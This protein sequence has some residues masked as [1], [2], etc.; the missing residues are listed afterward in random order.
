MVGMPNFV[1]VGQ[2]QMTHV[3]T[4]NI[5]H[6]PRLC[7]VFSSTVFDLVADYLCSVLYNTSI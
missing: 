4:V 7:P 6:F 2:D 1:A 5:I 3:C